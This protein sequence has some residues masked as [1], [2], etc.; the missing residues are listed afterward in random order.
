VFN[1]PDLD[2]GTTDEYIKAIAHHSQQSSADTL[3]PGEIYDSLKRFLQ[4]KSNGLQDTEHHASSNFAWLIS[5]AHR[6]QEAS[7]GSQSSSTSNNNRRQSSGFA[8]PERCLEALRNNI[9]MSHPQVL[10]L[11]GH[12]SPSW[13]ASIGPFCYVDPELFRWFLRYRAAPGSDYYFDS[14]P[15]TSKI[16]RFKFFTIGSKNHRY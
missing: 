11:R 2:Q 8:D 1:G 12:P 14:A 16:F 6:G 9:E 5:P 3:Y 10:F 4:Q 15:T 13:L 7:W